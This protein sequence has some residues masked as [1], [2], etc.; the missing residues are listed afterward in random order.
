MI[1]LLNSKNITLSEVEKTKFLP[2]MGRAY[3]SENHSELLKDPT[4]EKIFDLFKGELLEQ[5]KLLD[6]YSK[7]LFFMRAFQFDRIIKNI[8]QSNEKV[9]LVNAGAGLDTINCRIKAKNITFYDLDLPESA[10]LRQ[11]LIPSSSNTF[12]ISG[13]FLD[14]KWIEQLNLQKNDTL[15]IM[16]A[17]LFM[18]LPAAEI[19]SLLKQLCTIHPNTHILFDQTS[20]VGKLAIKKLLKKSGL[21]NV[22]LTSKMNLS[23]LRHTFPSHTIK[24]IPYWSHI[25][26]DNAICF[27]DRLKMTLCDLFEMAY[28]VHLRKM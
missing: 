26:N 25:R 5:E 13:S 1:N 7:L 15:I 17:G 3:G 18:Y 20:Y 16:A 19:L 23:D 6:N 10:K 14:S 11:F 8:A 22:T 4:A 9:K 2:L 12:T 24:K 27:S 28:L 21:T